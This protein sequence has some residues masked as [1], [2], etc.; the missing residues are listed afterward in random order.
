MP[1]SR[2]THRER[3]AIAAGLATHVGYAEIARRLGRPTSTIS[4]EVTRNGGPAGYRAERAHRSTAHRA[5]RRPGLRSAPEASG[6]A[7]LRAFVERFA[8]LMADTGV[9]RMASR[10][11][12]R[13]YV[14]DEGAQT[15]ADLVAHLRVSPASISTAIRYLEGLDLI[16]RERAAGTRRDRYSVDDD[17]WLRAWRTSARQHAEWAAAAQQ[18][19]DLLGP[20]TPAGARLQAMHGFFA[21]LADDMSGGPAPELISDALT[22][23]AALVHLGEPGD[24]ERLTT[25]LGWAPERLTRAMD[26][27]AGHPELGGPVA[28]EPVP[29]GGYRAAPQPGLLTPAQRAALAHP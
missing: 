8:A 23:L 26:A 22:V 4:R 10:V 21:R 14:T 2:L 19:A 3:E 1:G 12:T 11:L 28:V 27:I 9:P 15:A 18:G 13:L 16:R 17:V 29:G 7:A 25:A 6:D 5:S 20:A 24:A